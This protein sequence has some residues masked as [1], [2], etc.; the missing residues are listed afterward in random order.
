MRP[1]VRPSAWTR[2]PSSRCW[3]EPMATTPVV[4]V[5]QVAPS[6]DLR[7]WYAHDPEKFEEFTS[8]YRQ[9]LTDGE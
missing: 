5:K 1:S 4:Q 6:P 9:E 3:A 2:C 8:R 7:K